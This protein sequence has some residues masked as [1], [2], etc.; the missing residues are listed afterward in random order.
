MKPKNSAAQNR[1]YGVSLNSATLNT[2]RSCVD[3]TRGFM[4]A[5]GMIETPNMMNAMIRVVHP[6]PMVGSNCWNI[7]G[8]TIGSCVMGHQLS[9]HTTDWNDSLPMLLPI[10]K[11]GWKF[12]SRKEM[13]VHVKKL[14][15]G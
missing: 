4:P 9:D 6:K 13:V 10:D 1:R 5:I 14:K 2:W 3:G 7:V 12:F 8:K 11:N 15:Q